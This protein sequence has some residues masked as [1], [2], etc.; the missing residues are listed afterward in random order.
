MRTISTPPTLY[1]QLTDEC[2]LHCAYCYNNKRVPM[3]TNQDIGDIINAIDEVNPGKVIFTGGEP[4]LCSKMISDIIRYYELGM[5]RHWKAVISSNLAMKLTDSM[6]D[7]LSL[8]EFIQ[9]TYTDE[10]FFD[11]VDC[12]NQIKE[13]VKYIRDNFKNIEAIDCTITLTENT[14]INHPTP[15]VIWGIMSTIG[16]D[17]YTIEFM[18]NYGD[19]TEP[20]KYYQY[21]DDFLLNMI[22]LEE[23]EV[24]NVVE[25]HGNAN[26]QIILDAINTNIPI[27][28]YICQVSNNKYFHAPSNSLRDGCPCSMDIPFNKKEKFQKKCIECEFF[29]YCRMGCDRFTDS[30]GFPFKTFTYLKEQNENARKS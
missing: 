3:K 18:S 12:G 2:N 29:R 30:C 23:S 27:S 21:A 14:L 17:S 19:L 15:N 7:A 8:V 28:C 5:N 6:K 11:D 24:S 4:L 26:R 10:R 20:D 16:F 22:K 25:Y 13:N 9:T 1:I